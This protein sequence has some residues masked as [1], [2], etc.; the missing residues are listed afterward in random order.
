MQNKEILMSSS[1]VNEFGDKK[2][3]ETSLNWAQMTDGR[4]DER[5][6]IYRTNL[7]REEISFHSF[8]FWVSENGKSEQ[9][10]FGQQ[11]QAYF[12]NLSRFETFL[13]AEQKMTQS[14]IHQ[15]HVK[16]LS[17]WRYFKTMPIREPKEVPVGTSDMD[18]CSV[19]FIP[20]QDW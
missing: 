17:S 7:L 3:L 13:S 1:R 9:G 2:N 20:S 14:L 5:Q 18:A 8:Q 10:L 12:Y 15:E 16:K 6:Q 19:S 11:T 4:T